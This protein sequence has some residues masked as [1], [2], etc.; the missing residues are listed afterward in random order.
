MPGLGKS[1]ISRICCLRLFIRLA[2]G[3]RTVLW[4]GRGFG[5]NAGPGRLDGSGWVRRGF[6]F[7]GWS[8]DLFGL[9]DLRR[10]F[11]CGDVEALALIRLYFSGRVRRF[12]R[13]EARRLLIRLGR[14]GISG[15]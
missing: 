9:S 5:F 2:M 8:F 10:I 4:H 3:E 11:W 1:G 14:D 7:F 15:L 6:N 12:L 13:V